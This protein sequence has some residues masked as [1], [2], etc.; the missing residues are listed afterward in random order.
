MMK[1][2]CFLTCFAASRITNIATNY[3]SNCRHIANTQWSYL[4]HQICHK[5]HLSSHNIPKWPNVYCKTYNFLIITLC[6]SWSYFCLPPRTWRTRL[7]TICFIILLCS[8]QYANIHI[9]TSKQFHVG[10]AHHVDALHSTISV[11]WEY[12]LYFNNG[13][14]PWR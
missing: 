2:I 11:D 1:I 14:P 12:R 4:G 10:Y 6:C 5:V 13:L 9:F 3:S 8:L 7:F